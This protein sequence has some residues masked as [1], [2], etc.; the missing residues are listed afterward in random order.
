M[1]RSSSCLPLLA[2]AAAAFTLHLSAPAEAAP[3]RTILHGG[4]VFTADPES[5]WAQ[6]IAIEGHRVIAVGTD[7]EVMSLA[8][9]GTRLIDLAGRAV[10]PGL[11]DAHVHVLAPEGA[12][13]NDPT[14][15]IPGDGPTFAEVQGMIAGAAASLPPGTP[16]FAFIGAAVFD[17]PAADRFALDT[18]SPDHPVVLF[19]WTGHGTWLNTR[20]MEMIG[21]SESEPDPF[22][23][24]F[25]R[26]AGSS[27]ITGEAHE[28]AEYAVRRR[29]YD[30]LPDDHLVAQY[31]A[32]AAAAATFG[33]TSLQDIPVGLTHERALS[34][35]ADADLPIRVRSLCFPLTPDEPCDEPCQGLGPMVNGD[36]V[37][38]I[39]DG[40]P[41]ERLACVETAYA[42]QPGGY[43]V[44]NV[45]AGPMRKILRDHRHGSA[46]REQVLFHAVGDGAAERILDGMEQTGGAPVW[47]HRRTRIEHGDLLFPW[48][49]GRVR[50][51][52]VVVVQN[53]THLAS[54]AT[55]AERFDPTVFAELEP[56]RSLL[57]EG[58]PLA[59]GTDGIGRAQ[60]PFVDLFLA[61]IHPTRPSEALTLEQALIAYTH[62]S[63]YAEHQEH[64][65]GTLAPGKL[66]DLAVLS[67]DIF[68][69]PPVAIPATYSVLTIV[70][71]KVIWDAGVVQ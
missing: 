56:L 59:L 12:Y 40:T 1:F 55:F 54:T 9:P 44:C 17:D 53:A 57:E 10:I 66:A 24:Y 63:A 58:I 49:L 36:G 51:M 52:G 31:R 48:E 14:S 43:G 2:A 70:H 5:L 71:G 15:F 33:Y 26:A 21:L 22:G 27:I 38:W 50:D 42:D 20:A 13:L 62:G 67:Q 7:A 68:H 41:I 34:V 47:R 69:V 60:S 23:G 18:V 29:L 64:K 30:L 6:A 25:V 35:L 8:R 46:A 16:L 3:P 37:K 19:A 39:T 11:N 45:S 65:K 61:T 28:Y 4:T 32:F